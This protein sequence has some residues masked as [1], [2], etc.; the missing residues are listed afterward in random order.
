MENGLFLLHLFLWE[1]I[2]IN[3]YSLHLKPL[4]VKRF[5]SFIVLLALCWLNQSLA[6]ATITIKVEV[7][8]IPLKHLISKA[9]LDCA[10]Q[11]TLCQWV[12]LHSVKLTKP[13]DSMFL[14]CR[15]CQFLL[16]PSLYILFSPYKLCPFA[17]L[18]KDGVINNHK[19]LSLDSASIPCNHLAHYCFASPSPTL[20]K[21]MEWSFKTIQTMYHS[22][23]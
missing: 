23:L 5:P 10:M 19:C 16:K 9:E 7:G 6:R 17:E 1:K 8:S 14:Q 3:F 2:F 11:E 21:K 13:C 20:C 22:L 15:S 18:C 4:F 12:L